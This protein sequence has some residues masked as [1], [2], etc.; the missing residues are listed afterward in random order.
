MNKASFLWI[1][2]FFMLLGTGIQASAARAE[3]IADTTKLI[4]PNAEHGKEA[5]LITRLLLQNHY[6]KTPLNDSLSNVIFNNY[7]TNLDNNRMYFV[8]S[9]IE[10]FKRYKDYFDNYLLTGNIDVPFQMFRLYQERALDR[11]SKVN[12]ILETEP[13]FNSDEMFTP[14][15][16]KEPWAKSFDELDELWRKTIKYQALGLKLEGKE[17]K[18]IKTT[19]ASR[20]ARYHKMIEQYNSEDAFQM[21]MNSFTEAFDPHTNYFSPITSEN[22]QID[23]AQ[24]LEGIG[25]RLT[26]QM[27][28][29]QVYEVIPGGPAY[30]SKQIYKD[31][32]I[33]AV[34]Q[35]DKEDFVDVIGWRLDDVVQLIRGPKGTVVRLKIVPHDAPDGS[36]PVELRLVRDKVKLEEETASKKI[37]PYTEGGTTYK[38]GVITL[39]SFYFDWEG[40]QKGE[41]DYKSATRDVKRL[42]AELE[43]D[44]VDGVMMDLRFNG[45]GSL[46]EAINLSGLFI[47]KGPVVQVKNADGSIDVG[48][49][50]DSEIAY[51]GPLAVLVNRFSAS[52][53][54]IFA[55]AIQ[56]YKR[57]III[58]ENSFGKG[59]V[60]QLVDLDQF[61][62][63]ETAKLGQVKLTLSKY[64]RVNGSSTQ[65]LGVKPD[66]E[67]PSAYDADNFGESSQPSALPWD[68]IRS[69]SFTPVNKIDSKLIEQ[70]TRIYSLDLQN[71]AEFKELQYD[72]E[73]AKKA[74]S[75]NEISLNYNIRKAEIDDVRAA[76]ESI[77]DL[78]TQINDSEV[79]EAGTDRK[80]PKDVYLDESLKLLAN[81]IKIRLG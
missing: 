46:Q 62:P 17:W 29:T 71:N 35:G 16:E 75:K 7:I 69:S 38:L 33:V 76:R 79:K 9:D 63:Q 64:Y 74:R 60:Q 59:T 48:T 31:D 18:D 30:K 20:Y 52:A 50:K 54:E 77:R 26:Q 43:A 1:A 11:I 14:D 10:Y 41:K 15:R 44:G 28:N 6:R 4:V 58:G 23:M 78:S 53:S 68:Q 36:L 56:D 73:E 66:I 2:L 39:P 22:F 65:H 61:L 13:D 8:A 47:S 42:L 67:F 51:N 3:V 34:A 21:F 27:D 37:V 81:L 19:L 72:I 55:G 24:S 40:A 5:L 57:G 70:L 45:G 32:K 12:K 49:D 80:E 25:A